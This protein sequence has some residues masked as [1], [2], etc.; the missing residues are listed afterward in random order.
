MSPLCRRL[1]GLSEECH[2]CDEMA[3]GILP[4]QVQGISHE[5][6]QHGCLF[7]CLRTFSHVSRACSGSVPPAILHEHAVDARHGTYTQLHELDLH[8]KQMVEL[9]EDCTSTSSADNL[10]SLRSAGK[11]AADYMCFWSVSCILP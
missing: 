11:H 1:R 8:A 5:M 6:A 7:D 9:A 4:E 10:T 2:P 3:G